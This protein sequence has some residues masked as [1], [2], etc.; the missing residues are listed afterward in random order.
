MG[1]ILISAAK[2]ELLYPLV[3]MLAFS[4]AFALPFFLLAMFPGYLAKLPK[5][6]SWLA[7]VKGFMGFLEIAAAVKFFSNADL[8]W[9]TGIL[10]RT[11]FL[12]VWVAIFV[13][14]A[15]FLAGIV[16][17]P[18]VDM[19]KKIGPGRVVI[20]A[21]TVIA[22]GFFAL[23]MTGKSLGEMEAYLP[24]SKSGW[25]ESYEKA[26]DLAKRENK[27]VFVNFT[28]VT[29]TNCRWMEKNM[30]PNPDVKKELGN[31]VLVELYT[32]KQSKEDQDNQALQQKLTGTV[33]LPVYLTVAPDG[34]VISKFE[35][36]TRKTEEFLTFLRTGKS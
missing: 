36:S 18:T 30:F 29:C 19:P 1:T 26:L 17:L 3:G 25:M 2:G 15:L 24:P 31:Y 21:L 4:T 34:H 20:M 23:G 8:V 11:L 6:G 33:A 22:A 5:S 12:G 35:S 14:A 9:G 7:A 32:D 10:S 28:G 16:R 27:P 13:V